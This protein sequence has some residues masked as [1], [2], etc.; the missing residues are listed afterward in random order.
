MTNRHLQIG[1]VGTNVPAPFLLIGAVSHVMAARGGGAGSTSG[2]SPPN[3]AL[4]AADRAAP[5]LV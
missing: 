2:R 3:R 1:A 5:V 4:Q